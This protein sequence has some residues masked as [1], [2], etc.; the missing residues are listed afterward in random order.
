M[1]T[2]DTSASEH[3]LIQS[4]LTHAWRTFKAHGRIGLADMARVYIR[5]LADKGSGPVSCEILYV[6]RTLSREALAL[7]R[8][9]WR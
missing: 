4:N 9:E 3:M 2:I 5:E 8:E 1:T 6:N 7:G